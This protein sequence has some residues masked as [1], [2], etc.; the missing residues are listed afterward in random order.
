MNLKWIFDCSE[1]TP[2]L[3]YRDDN[4]SLSP[5]DIINTQLL[6]ITMFWIKQHIRLYRKYVH[7]VPVN[8]SIITFQYW[9]YF[10]KKKITFGHIWIVQHQS[11]FNKIDL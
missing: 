3:T 8:S 11:I 10:E 1:D 5:Y 7:R 6:L 9:I 2:R 4:A